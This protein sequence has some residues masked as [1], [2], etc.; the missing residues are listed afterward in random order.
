MIAE[1]MATAYAFT[2]YSLQLP[3]SLRADTDHHL[4]SADEDGPCATCPTLLSPPDESPAHSRYWSS[5]VCPHSNSV[6]SP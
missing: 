4:K 6:E 1:R 2:S 3:S 5:T